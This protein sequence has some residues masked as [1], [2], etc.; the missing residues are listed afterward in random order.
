MFLKCYWSSG[1]QIVA[2]RIEWLRALPAVGV[3][4]PPVDQPP[5]SGLRKNM[6]IAGDLRNRGRASRCS[7]GQ[8]VERPGALPAVG[9]QPP[10]NQSPIRG[11]RKDVGE[12][13]DIRGDWR[14]GNGRSAQ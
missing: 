5:V 10:V 9:V 6:R 1:N 14:P 13:S 4:Q 2:R 12:T 3:V 11:L 7:P 8:R